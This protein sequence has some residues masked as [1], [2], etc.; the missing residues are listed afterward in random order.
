MVKKVLV[1]DVDETILNVEPLFF[2]EKFKKNYEQINGKL[3]TFPHTKK[4]FY[5]SLRPGAKE[6]LEKAKKAFKLVAFSVADREATEIKLGALG[7]KNCFEKVYGK[8]DLINKK[9]CLELVSKDFNVSVNTI[10]AID[11]KPQNFD[12]QERVIKITPWY[13]GS[14]AKNELIAGL[15]QARLM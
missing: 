7:L 2:L 4:K 11:D 1:V 9:K 14:E 13:V 10:I 12:F 3:V 8:E 6:F 5:M 15:K